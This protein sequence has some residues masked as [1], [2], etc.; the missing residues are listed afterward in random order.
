MHARCDK[1]TARAIRRRGTREQLGK[2]DQQRQGV[3]MQQNPEHDRHARELQWPS[4]GSKGA[5]A[6]A[7]GWRRGERLV[8]SQPG[9]APAQDRPIPRPHLGRDGL[10]PVGAGWLGSDGGCFPRGASLRAQALD[11]RVFYAEAMAIRYNKSMAL[12]AL[13]PAPVAGLDLARRCRPWSPPDPAPK[14]GAYLISPLHQSPK[15]KKTESRGQ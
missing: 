15:S 14:K 8:P 10:A 12:L 9:G 5:P 1:H 7:V 3:L 4:P 6:T 11:A 2:N 13:S